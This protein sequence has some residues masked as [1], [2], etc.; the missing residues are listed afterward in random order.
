MQYMN[1]SCLAESSVTAI[2]PNVKENVLT[3]AVIYILL[4]YFL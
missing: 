2:K 3:A 1:G 4:K